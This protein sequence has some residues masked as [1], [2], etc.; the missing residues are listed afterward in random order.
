MNDHLKHIV[1]FI[2]SEISIYLTEELSA[3]CMYSAVNVYMI[4]NQWDAT[5]DFFRH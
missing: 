4:V 2:S 5:F 3:N 1:C